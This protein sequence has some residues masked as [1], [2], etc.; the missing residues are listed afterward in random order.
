M[1]TAGTKKRHGV[2]KAEQTWKAKRVGWDDE[3]V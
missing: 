3:V 2:S 1:C